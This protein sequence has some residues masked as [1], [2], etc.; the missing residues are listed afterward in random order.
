MEKIILDKLN[1]DSKIIKKAGRE[2]YKC[3]D[4]KYI[5][6]LIINEIYKNL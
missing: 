6:N 3:K 2:Y 1:K 4:H 5:I